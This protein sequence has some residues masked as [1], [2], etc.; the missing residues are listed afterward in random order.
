MTGRDGGV[1]GGVTQVYF[2]LRFQSIPTRRAGG[3]FPVLSTA[4]GAGSGNLFIPDRFKMCFRGRKARP[5][6]HKTE[7]WERLEKR[8]VKKR[9]H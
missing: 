9:G 1:R 3:E 6:L 5:E 4:A 8:S 7:G 2:T